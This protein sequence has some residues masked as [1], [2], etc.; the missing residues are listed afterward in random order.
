MHSEKKLRRKEKNLNV[1]L[2]EVLDYTTNLT[3]FLLNHIY[4]RSYINVNENIVHYTHLQSAFGSHLPSNLLT[5]TP[6]CAS[7][8][9]S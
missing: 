4:M 7:G 6:S 5:V 1:D 8:L 3:E 9:L 2:S